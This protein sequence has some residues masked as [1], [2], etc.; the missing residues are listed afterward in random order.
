VVSNAGGPNESEFTAKF[1][2]IPFRRLFLAYF[3]EL[4]GGRQLAAP[5]PGAGA[6]R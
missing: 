2:Y 3:R 4:A 6:L 5:E 1:A